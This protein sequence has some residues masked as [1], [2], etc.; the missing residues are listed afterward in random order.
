MGQSI[1]GV[2]EIVVAAAPSAELAY[3]GRRPTTSSA[4]WVATWSHQGPG[5]VDS[6]GALVVDVRAAA[7]APV[8]DARFQRKA[9]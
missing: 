7:G 8:D 4:G 3:Q 9:R 5:L 2:L 6:S 1:K